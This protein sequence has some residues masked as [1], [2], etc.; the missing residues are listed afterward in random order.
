MGVAEILKMPRGYSTD[1]RWGI[2][3]LHRYKQLNYR[4][5]ANLLYIHPSTV[6][7]VVTRYNTT[8]D[9]AP[10]TEYK[11]GPPS[12]LEHPELLNVIIEAILA[13]PS[14]YLSELRECLHQVAG[15]EISISTIYRALKRLGFTRKKLRHIIIRQ[16]SIAREQYMEEVSYLNTKMIVWVDETGNDQRNG[17]RNFGYHLRGMTPTS[18]HLN[19]HGKHLSTISIMSSRGIEDF[20]TYSSNWCVFG[21]FVDRCLIPILQPFDGVNA[22]SVVVMDNAAIHHVDR[23]IQS[24]H[25]AGAIIKFLPPY[26]PDLDPLEEAF[27]KVKSYLKANELAYD[28]TAEPALLIALAFN[29]ITVEDCIGYIQH[30]G[31]Q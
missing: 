28:I 3:W 30:A 22:R 31:Y 14:I 25:N 15:I 4:S 2:L 8:R 29:T 24:V 23:V 6:S 16:C 1:L 18:Y 19:T 27:A 13:H 26:S 12:I 9:V 20:D 21:D 5:I 17:R 10:I 7:R 11:H